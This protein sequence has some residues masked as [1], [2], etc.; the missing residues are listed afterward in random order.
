MMAIERTAPKATPA[1][2]A[3]PAKP[4][5]K[6]K[7]AA[8]SKPDVLRTELAEARREQALGKLDS[9]AKLR[10]LRRDLARALTIER[11]KAGK[12]PS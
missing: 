3:K 9:P 7:P 5:G 4:D 2:A 6:N 11:A 1:A 12:E 10:K 8:P